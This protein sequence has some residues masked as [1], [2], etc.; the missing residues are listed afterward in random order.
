MYP[1]NA[2]G[3]YTRETRQEGKRTG[4]EIVTLGGRSAPLANVNFPKIFRVGKYGV[5][6]QGLEEVGIPS[7]SRAMRDNCL[8]VIDE[9]GPMELFSHLF[10]EAVIKALDGSCNVLGTI[11]LKNLPFTDE[12]K[13]RSDVQIIEVKPDSREELLPLILEKLSA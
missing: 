7:L 9:I 13:S 1:G 3:F 11:Y 5:D 6:L 2:G 8:V 4:F 12:I 10:R